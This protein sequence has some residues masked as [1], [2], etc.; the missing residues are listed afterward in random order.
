VPSDDRLPAPGDM[1]VPPWSGWEEVLAGV[2][3]LMAA[4]V[5]LLLAA[6]AR[7]G[8][9]ERADW[10]AW[11]DARPSRR[12]TPDVG[13]GSVSPTASVPAPDRRPAPP[14]RRDGGPA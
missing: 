5:V 2:L 8:A 12:P 9:G 13:P 3:V 14:A 11:L 10:Q 4:G 6:L 1:T 7:G